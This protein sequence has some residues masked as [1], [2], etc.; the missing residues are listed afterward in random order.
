[1]PGISIA[2]GNRTQLVMR[3]SVFRITI[4]GVLKGFSDRVCLRKSLL[5][6]KWLGRKGRS[7][8]RADEKK[9]G[10][11]HAWQSMNDWK[12]EINSKKYWKLYVKKWQCEDKRVTVTDVTVSDTTGKRESHVCKSDT[13]IP[14]SQRKN[15]A[16]RF[17]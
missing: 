11:A 4:P 17:Q 1:M 7:Q 12:K 2:V 6:Q 3:K 10:E 15:A 13:V 16:L 9:T 5:M 14:A 8:R